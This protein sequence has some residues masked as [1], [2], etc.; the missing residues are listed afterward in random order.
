MLQELY[1]NGVDYVDLHG[2]N[3]EEQDSIDISFKR[4][5][6][7]FK[8][9]SGKEEEEENENEDISPKIITKLS[10]DNLNQLL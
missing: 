1:E 6:T 2:T 8:D 5:Y 9:T 7:V 10:D 4:E 3:D